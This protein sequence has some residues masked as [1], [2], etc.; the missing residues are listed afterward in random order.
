MWIKCS[1]CGQ[2]EWISPTSE[3]YSDYDFMYLMHG[4]KSIE[5][6]MAERELDWFVLDD[7]FLCDDCVKELDQIGYEDK[8][9]WS[10]ELE[11]DWRQELLTES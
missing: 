1:R 3:D 11:D 6:F 10:R 5:G 9:N 4:H 8:G 7:L 2:R